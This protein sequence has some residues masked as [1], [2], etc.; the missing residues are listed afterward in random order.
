MAT[1]VLT[2]VGLG[3]VGLFGFLNGHRWLFSSVAVVL[4]ALSFYQSVIRRPSRLNITVFSVA[5]IFVVGSALV[6]LIR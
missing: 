2:A 5:A 1:P 3:G 6:S 4:L